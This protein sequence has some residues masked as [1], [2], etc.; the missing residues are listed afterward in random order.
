M[1]LRNGKR[2]GGRPV[3]GAI[4]DG[5]QQGARRWRRALMDNRNK[6]ENNLMPTK[7]ADMI[8]NV[9]FDDGKATYGSCT[10]KSFSKKHIKLNR[11]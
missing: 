5:P 10:A 1:L 11:K 8:V 2:S 3:C 4:N 6:R 7:I 9:N